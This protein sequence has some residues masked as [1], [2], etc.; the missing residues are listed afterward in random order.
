MVNRPRCEGKLGAE[1]ALGS[2]FSG[3]KGFLRADSAKK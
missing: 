2:A 3:I 1:C